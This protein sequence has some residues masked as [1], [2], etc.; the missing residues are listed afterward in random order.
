MNQLQRSA[1]HELQHF[2]IDRIEVALHALKNIPFSHIYDFG[3]G[4]ALLPT[5]LGFPSDRYTG[6]DKTPFH[7][8][9]HTLDLETPNLPD[10]K[11]G[12]QDVCLF[13][14]V[15]EHISYRKTVFLWAVQQ[16]PIMLFTWG[17]NPEDL[18]ALYQGIETDFELTVFPYFRSDKTYCEVCRLTRRGKPSSWLTDNAKT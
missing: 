9:V 16:F 3:C 14:G 18:K 4:E 10:M 1:L 11:S 5:V 7:P 17:K 15:F 13:L 2:F 12:P 6:Y 8:W